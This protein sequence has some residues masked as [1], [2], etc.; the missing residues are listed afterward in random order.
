MA[1]IQ[2]EIVK[3]SRRNI[4]SRLLHAKNDKEEIAG[5]K[6]DL[7]GILHVFNVCALLPMFG[8]LSHPL[9]D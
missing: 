3:Q 4:G 6:L 9:A 2:S 5:W 1:E 8:H 7:N